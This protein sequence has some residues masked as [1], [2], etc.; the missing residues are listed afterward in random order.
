MSET[1]PK[2]MTI[3]RPG[4][5][6]R[7]PEGI[8]NAPF[9]VEMLLDN[10]VDGENTAMRATLDPGTVTHW[11]TH[12]RGQLLYVLSGIGLVQRKDEPAEEVRTGDAIW[13]APDELH[14]H[15][16]AP[17]S[18]FSYLSVQGSENG[19]FVDWFDSEEPQP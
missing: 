13:F 1:N 11:H 3:R 9:W 14:R 17:D 18:P 8:S 15:G 19:H 2:T 16:A 5:A 7:S 4:N 10:Q 6:V 12:P